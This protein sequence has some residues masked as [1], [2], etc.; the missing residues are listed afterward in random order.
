MAALR[1]NCAMCAALLAGV[2]AAAGG[3]AAAP[4]TTATRGSLPGLAEDQP[5]QLEARSSDFDYRSNRLQFRG[6]RISQGGLAVEADEATATGLDFKESQWV[7]RGNV[8]ITVPDGFLTSDEAHVAFADN[9]IASAAASGSPAAFEQKRD[10][11]I[12]RGHA[13]RI[14]Y[15]FGVG[16][17]RLAD[18][19]WLSDGG[20]EITGQTLVYNFKDQRIRANPEEQGGQRVRITINPR[21]SAPK[22]NP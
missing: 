13:G 14:D 16:T 8:R 9:A 7:F 6:I 12:A 20:T 19:A 10:N 4:T 15:D 21:T 1:A 11:G 22:P 5:I 17:V 2:L 18:D 3:N